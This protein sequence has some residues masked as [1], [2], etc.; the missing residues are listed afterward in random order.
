MSETRSLLQ[1]NFVVVFLA[2]DPWGESK[3]GGGDVPASDSDP[4]GPRLRC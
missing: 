4:F 3:L 1:F 2:T